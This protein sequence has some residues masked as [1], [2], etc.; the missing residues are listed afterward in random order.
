MLLQV[1]LLKQIPRFF[2]RR[3]PPGVSVGRLS[4]AKDGLATF[5]GEEFLVHPSLL[6]D[7]VHWPYDSLF[8]PIEIPDV[9]NLRSCIN[10]D[11]AFIGT[12]SFGTEGLK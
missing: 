6:V 10:I 8:P 7:H 12:H 5:V 4:Q 2:C 1:G 11:V 9:E 3:V